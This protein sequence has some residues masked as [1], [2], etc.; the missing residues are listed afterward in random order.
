M[1]NTFD[2]DGDQMGNLVLIGIEPRKHLL[3]DMEGSMEDEN[4]FAC[5][6]VVLVDILRTDNGDTGTHVL[7][8]DTQRH[9]MD[10]GIFLIINKGKAF[11]RGGGLDPFH[12]TLFSEATVNHLF[13]GGFISLEG[14]CQGEL[15]VAIVITNTD[16]IVMRIVAF[17]LVE[18]LECALSNIARWQ[19]RIDF[20]PIAEGVIFLIDNLEHGHE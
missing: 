13:D 4:Q 18:Y 12:G 1:G 11:Q 2:G 14:F 15:G 10:G 6:V 9:T 7:H 17:N 20:F 8:G 3:E 5:L 19:Q 16:N